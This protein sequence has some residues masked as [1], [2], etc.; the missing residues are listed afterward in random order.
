MIGGLKQLPRLRLEGTG[1]FSLWRSHP[2]FAKEGTADYRRY[3]APITLKLILQ[4]QTED[5][6][7]KDRRR[8]MER[9]HGVLREVC[10]RTRTRRPRGDR[11][12]VGH[13]VQAEDRIESAQPFDRE[14]HSLA[15]LHIPERERRKDILRQA[16]RLNLKADIALCGLSAAGLCTRLSQRNQG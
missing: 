15:E 9:R 13:V 16:A 12:R 5:P 2:S 6:R 14:L 11:V 3:L 4:T 7:R 8:T 1:S 10:K